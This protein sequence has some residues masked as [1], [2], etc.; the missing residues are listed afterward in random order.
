MRQ[1]YVA[2]TKAGREAAAAA[3]LAQRE[4]EVYLPLAPPAR[5]AGRRRAAGASGF[6]TKPFRPTALLD[7]VA[8]LAGI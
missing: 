1:W 7:L 2:K 6:L 5:R 3:V 8:S 4:V